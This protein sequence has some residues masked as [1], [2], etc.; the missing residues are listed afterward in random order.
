MSEKEKDGKPKDA[1][2]DLT[3]VGGRPGEAPS[4]PLHVPVGIQVLVAKASV[5]AEFRAALLR[6]RSEA[7]RRIR[8]ALTPA[9]AG[10]LNA[11]PEEQLEVMIRNTKVPPQYQKVFMGCAVAAMLAVI[12]YLAVRYLGNNVSRQFSNITMGILVE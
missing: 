5:D 8:L 6:E 7:A 1:D 2:P 4:A 10:I 3:I 11:L 12:G 9:E